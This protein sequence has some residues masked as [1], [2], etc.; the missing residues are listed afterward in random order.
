MVIQG[1]MTLITADN[2]LK[3][4]TPLGIKS[5]HLIFF[6]FVCLRMGESPH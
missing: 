5:K 6:D 4:K 3:I 2:E 1:R